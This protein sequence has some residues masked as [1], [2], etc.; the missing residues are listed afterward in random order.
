VFVSTILYLQTYALLNAICSFL[1]S[2]Y[3]GLERAFFLVD[4]G[5]KQFTSN[6]DF[7]SNPLTQYVGCKCMRLRLNLVGLDNVAQKSHFI[8]VSSLT[9]RRYEEEA[10]SQL[11]SIH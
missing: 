1:F 8:F 9:A 4:N 6:V 2:R 10:N 3:K 5:T 7:F 11:L